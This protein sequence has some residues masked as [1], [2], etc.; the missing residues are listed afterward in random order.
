M[1]RVEQY[2][3]HDV[4]HAGRY[5]LRLYQDELAYAL[6]QI[7]A[8]D[9]LVSLNVPADRKRVWTVNPAMGYLNVQERYCTTCLGFIS[10]PTPMSIGFQQE[11]DLQWSS[12]SNS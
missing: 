9:A 3:P 5:H 11:V 1:L 6:G 4:N 7:G 10:D 8:F 12:S 2:A